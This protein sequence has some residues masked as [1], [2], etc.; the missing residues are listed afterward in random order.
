MSV[1]EQAGTVASMSGISPTSVRNAFTSTANRQWCWEKKPWAESGE[2]VRRAADVRG[3]LPQGP[4][5]G[6]REVIWGG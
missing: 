3:Y 2:M 4:V 1:T 6:L 5:V